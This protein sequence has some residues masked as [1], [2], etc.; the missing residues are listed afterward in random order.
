MYKQIVI[1][2]LPCPKGLELPISTFL[3]THKPIHTYPKTPPYGYL[4]RNGS[5]VL[6]VSYLRFSSQLRKAFELL[7]NVESLSG[8]QLL[9]KN[10]LCDSSALL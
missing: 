6:Y 8:S 2:C 1:I 7:T 3:P 4:Y 5:F 10:N 9:D